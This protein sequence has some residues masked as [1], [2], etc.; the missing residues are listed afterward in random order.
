MARGT[1]FLIVGPSGAGKDSLIRGAEAALSSSKK[2]VFAERAITRTVDPDRESHEPVTAAEFAKRQKAKAFML[3]WRVYDTD[4][5]IPA[6]YEDDL[7]VGRH[8]VANVSRGIV[9]G[10]VAHF[11]PACVIQITAPPPVLEYRL[12]SRD[13]IKN[14]AERLE[15]TV[16]LPDGISVNHLLNTKDL[17]T[18]VGRL[19]GMLKS[20]AKA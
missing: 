6:S 8:V 1:F 7:K 11:R 12:K 17:E 9:G 2:Y 14:L 4:Y 18:G 13:D 3:T 5:G 19:V 10:A 16:M 20:L 15:R